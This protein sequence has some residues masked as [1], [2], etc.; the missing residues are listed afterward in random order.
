MKIFRIEHKDTLNGMWTHKSEGKIV[1]EHLEDDRLLKMPM[2]DCDSF[3]FDKKSWKTAV[4]DFK[5]LRDW[6]TQEEILEMTKHG[7]LI[8][9]IEVNF[10]DIITQDNQIIFDDSKR[11]EVL[12]ITESYFWVKENLKK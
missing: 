2:L 5:M 7:F 3:R 11:V 12:D 8:K 4:S 9:Q 6:F 10:C 1:L